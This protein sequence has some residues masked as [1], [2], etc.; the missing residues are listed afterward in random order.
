MRISL[1]LYFKRFYKY[2]ADVIFGQIPSLL[3]LLGYFGQQIAVMKKLCQI[4]V[5]KEL[6]KNCISQIFS[7]GE[8]WLM[9][10]FTKTTSCVNKV[11]ETIWSSGLEKII[12]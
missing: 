4:A 3:R 8:I 6:A 11:Y 7:F 10:L 9:R 5:M 12:F 1:L 2:L